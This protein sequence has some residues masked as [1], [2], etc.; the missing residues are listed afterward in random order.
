MKTLLKNC[1][2][3]EGLK[4]II[5]EDVKI[6]DI[7]PSE[8]LKTFRTVESLFDQI[9]D[10]KGNLIL[11]GFIDTHVHVR[12]M[13]MAYKETW[14]TA[15]KAAIAGGITTIIDMP[16][17]KPAT[18]NLSGLNTKR[19]AAEKSLVN[20]LFHLGVTENN[21]DE[22]RKILKQHPAD[23]AGIKVFL[24]GSSSNEVVQDPE[25]LK[26][27][28]KLAKEFDK[29]VLVH[30]EI[31]SILDK[32]Q[33]QAPEQSIQYH[34]II[35]HREA[36]IEGTKL[37]IDIAQKTGAKL[38][39]CHVSTKEEI[40]LI[41][42]AKKTNN[43]IFCEVTP[44]HLFL[45]E[46]ILQKIGNFGKV[47]PPLR[48]KEDNAVLWEAVLDGTIDTIGTDHAP[49]TKK[50]KEQ[51]YEKAPSGFP[52]LETA[53]PMLFKKMTERISEMEA[54]RIIS[55]LFSQNPVRIFGLEK[56]GEIKVGNFADLIVF[57]TNKKWKID[58]DKFQTKAR[59]SPF[60]GMIGQAKVKCTFVNGKRY[61]ET[62]PK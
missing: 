47:N 41:R 50:E 7:K 58:P 5:I 56:R 57:D 44:H 33:K 46:A 31:Q 52:G 42:A 21:L 30:T 19:K 37:V 26:V 2:L 9:I 3:I 39:V 18:T 23:V 60:D 55:K 10:I 4:D 29:V 24:A 16:N 34:N 15:S 43:N 49:H 59:Y 40:E 20:Y 17:T 36:A 6:I 25:K 12:D 28:F 38:Y 48:T 54:L 22:L 13:D 8:R 35:R 14:E 62:C 1:K 61:D 51:S 27:I 32:W 45:D 53:F 11:P